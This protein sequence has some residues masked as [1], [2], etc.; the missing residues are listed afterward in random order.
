MAEPVCLQDH[1]LLSLIDDQPV[2]SGLQEHLDN[3]L[4]CRQRLTQLRGE[5]QTL[6]ESVGRSDKQRAA[7]N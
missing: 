7:G 3:C 4:T 1:E 2:S 5:V 6:R